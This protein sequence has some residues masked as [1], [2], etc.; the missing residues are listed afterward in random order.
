M[1]WQTERF[2]NKD[3]YRSLKAT[4]IFGMI[5]FLFLGTA[6]ILFGFIYGLPRLANEAANT[7]GIPHQNAMSGIMVTICFLII[8]IAFYI[9]MLV[10]FIKL[11]AVPKTERKIISNG[12]AVDGTVLKFSLSGVRASSSM[13]SGLREKY[14][15]AKYSFIIDGKM[16]I[17]KS[18]SYFS[19]EDHEAMIR[20]GNRVKVCVF[21]GKSCIFDLR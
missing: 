4:W 5:M 12:Q 15:K 19:P 6:L 17:R 9:F 13:Q 7:N 3:S 18:P 10:K 21:N 20:N 14:Y 11:L 1:D 8:F 16:F 2:L